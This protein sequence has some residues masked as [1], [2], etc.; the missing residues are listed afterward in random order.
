[1]REFLAEGCYRLTGCSAVRN[2]VPEKV[3]TAGTSFGGTLARDAMLSPIGFAKSSICLA[4]ERCTIV[5]LY[6]TVSNKMQCNR[7]VHYR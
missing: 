5:K 1:M 3:S 2:R 7:E 6:G 4:K